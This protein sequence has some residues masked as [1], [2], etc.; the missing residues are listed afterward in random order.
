MNDEKAEDLEIVSQV[1]LGKT[2][3]FGKIVKRYEVAVRSFCKGILRDEHLAEDAAQDVFIKAF[4]RLSSFKGDAKFSTWL[5]R[6]TRNHCIDLLRTTKRRATDSLD[7]KRELGEIGGSVTASDQ[8]DQL[9]ARQTLLQVLSELSNEEREVLLLRELQ[10]YSY[11]EI[12]DITGNSLNSL[13]GKLKRVRAKVLK[14]S[15]HQD[16]QSDVRMLRSE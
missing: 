1:L 7:E 14:I 12:A 2:E 11:E 16:T 4:Q 13:K 9:N 6:I 3:L 5:F 10:G 8:G 15:R